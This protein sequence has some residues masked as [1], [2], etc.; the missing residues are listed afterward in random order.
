MG[1]I[2]PIGYQTLLAFKGDQTLK[3]WLCIV[4]ATVVL[5]TAFGCE[6]SVVEGGVWTTENL[7]LILEYG[8]LP[9][10]ILLLGFWYLKSANKQWG[11]MLE[12]QQRQFQEQNNQLIAAIVN[13]T[14]AMST[15][16][17]KLG[18]GCR[19]FDPTVIEKERTDEG[20]KTE[21]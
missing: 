8:G 21:G 9:A 7:K 6:K 13:N 3:K 18:M 15:L 10:V 14:V 1:R 19:L 12:S 11:K 16:T 20:T 4:V 5:A 17:T 2:G